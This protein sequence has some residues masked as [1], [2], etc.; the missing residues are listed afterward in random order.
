MK[1]KE[2]NLSFKTYAKKNSFNL[3]IR[4]QMKYLL[5]RRL[6]TKIINNNQ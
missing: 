5:L 1:S 3:M 4:G 6:N 2:Y